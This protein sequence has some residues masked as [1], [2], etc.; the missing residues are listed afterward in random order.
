MTARAFSVA[1]KRYGR[2][3]DTENDPFHQKTVSTRLA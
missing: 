2:F 3:F 1:N